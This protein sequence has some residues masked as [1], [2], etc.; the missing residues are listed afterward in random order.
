M[1][2]D[3]GGRES[4]RSFLDE[5]TLANNVSAIHRQ[6]GQLITNI[7][8]VTGEN[9]QVAPIVNNKDFYTGM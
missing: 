4:E 9:L 5:A 2:G 3:P 8:N 7:K 1:I 6:I